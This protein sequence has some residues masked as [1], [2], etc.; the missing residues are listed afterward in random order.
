MDFI[1]PLQELIE[2]F[3]KLKSVGRKTAQRYAFN[4]LEMTDDE[5]VSFATA[6]I[7][8]KKDICYCSICGNLTDKEIC[9][10]CSDESRNKDVICVVEDATDIMA[11][12]QTREYNG[13]Y[14]VLNGVISPSKGLTPDKLRISELL[15][16]LDKE[17]INELIIATNSG[18]D[19]ETTA[20]YLSRLV[21]NKNI[22]ITRPASGIPVGADI[23][24]ADKVTLAHALSGRTE[25]K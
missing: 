10:I 22:K 18:L 12:E 16:R 5:V 6:L 7:K 9:D 20:M 17:N 8:A 1:L 24:Y 25:L 23:V 13:L 19:G 2:Q 4:I 15:D 14:H 21:S 11:I 3:S